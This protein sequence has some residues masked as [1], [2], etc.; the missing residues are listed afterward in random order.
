MINILRKRKNLG[1]SQMDQSNMQDKHVMN[2]VLHDKCNV[3][4]HTMNCF[5]H[6]S[7]NINYHEAVKRNR[8]ALPLSQWRI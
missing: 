8:I 2:V 4:C 5:A 7:Q 6:A 1:S 3:Y